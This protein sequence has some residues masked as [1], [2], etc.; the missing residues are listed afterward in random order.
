MS[1]ARGQ[2]FFQMTRITKRY[3]MGSQRCYALR[4]VSLR[5]DAGE[6]VSVLGPSG[7]GK[8]TLM[9]IIGTLDVPTSGEYILR[10][11]HMERMTADERSD[12]RNREIGF[13]FQDFNLLP[14]RTILDNVALPLIFAGVRPSQRIKQARDALARVGLAGKLDYLPK[15]LSGGQPQRSAFARALGAGPSLLL[16]DEPTGALDQAT[17]LQIMRLFEALHQAGGTVIMITHDEK[18]A[19]H[20]T[21]IVR[22]VDGR[23]QEEGDPPC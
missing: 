22:L 16:A 21:R 20:G 13:V 7:S 14:N 1:D 6:F 12:L 10:G 3:L 18:L 4:G 9:N 5:I 19:A 15:Q 2:P 11:R 23:I 17:G 8:T